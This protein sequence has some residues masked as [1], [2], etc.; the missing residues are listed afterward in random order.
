MQG[1][2][3]LLIESKAYLDSI[4]AALTTNIS[5]H[6]V[7]GSGETY[8][9]INSDMSRY[10]QKIWTNT[11]SSPLKYNPVGEEFQKG[12]QVTYKY[13]LNLGLEHSDET[14]D[15]RV[16][17][18]AYTNH[19]SNVSVHYDL[20]HYSALGYLDE[21]TAHLYRV[22]PSVKL[23]TLRFRIAYEPNGATALPVSITRYAVEKGERE[24]LVDR[25]VVTKLVSSHSRLPTQHFLR[26]GFLKP[27]GFLTAA[28]Y[29]YES[30]EFK[31]FGPQSQLIT[32]F[33][34]D[35]PRLVRPV[36]RTKL[37]IGYWLT[38]SIILLIAAGGYIKGRT[39]Q[40]GGNVNK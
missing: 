1:D 8:W 6:I 26:D 29:F 16:R 5:A 24:R 34:P 21:I 32:R 31:T 9:I 25:I 37:L 36:N 35:D 2:R 33:R 4:P 12:L 11:T 38:A 39:K 15:P 10:E 18:G 7:A 17:R 19:L 3:L 14:V 13:L 22:E 23:S 30:N 40:R 20:S 28:T 27:S